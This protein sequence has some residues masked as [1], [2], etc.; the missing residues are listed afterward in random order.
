[1]EARMWPPDKRKPTS[2]KVG[3][4]ENIKAAQAFEYPENSHSII[5]LQ[6]ARVLERFRIS[7]PVARVVAE[8]H[9]GRA[10]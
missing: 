10:A 8:L 9:Y 1:M 2:A 7:M 5:D 4:L 6:A 3:S